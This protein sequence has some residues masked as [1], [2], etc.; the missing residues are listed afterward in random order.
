MKTCL[1]V[2]D[3]QN[4]FISIET[5]H[6]KQRI[7]KLLDANL[8]DYVIFS[9]FKNLPESPYRNILKWDNLTKPYEQELIKEIRPYANLVV[10]KGIYTVVNADTLRFIEEKNIEVAFVL[11]I[12][13]DCCVL[14]TAVDLFENN[15]RPF[16]LAY[17]SASN[18]G[19]ASHH[20][21]LTVLSRLIGVNSVI[22]GP[23]DKNV[24]AEI[25][26]A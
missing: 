11:G 9:K 13:T 23:I 8:F 17:Y 16:V 25:Q 20:A 24:M 2:V 3:I 12:D 22:E 6:T 5:S 18:G 26:Q 4:G 15:I 19:K 7:R 21:A 14:K 1:F 10:E